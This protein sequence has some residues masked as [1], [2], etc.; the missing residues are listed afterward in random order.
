MES[1]AWIG[2]VQSVDTGN[3]SVRVDKEEL[4]NSV[5]INQIV[6]I[7]STKTGEKIVGLISKIMRKA[8]SEKID[9]SSEP[10]LIVEN[11]MRVNLVGTLIEKSGIYENI[12]KRTLN[13]VPSIDAD[14]FLLQGEE[15]S[16]FMSII[17]SGSKNPLKIG[18][19]TISDESDAN[20]D[21]NKFFQRHAVIVGG[22]GSGKSWTV[23]NI[24]EKAA[25]L[26]SINSLVFDLH[27]EYKPLEDLPN[28]TL[29]KIAGPS[30]N[31]NE[32]N[33][34]FLP[35]WLLSYDEIESML[36][37]RSDSNA[38]NQ[39]RT[40]FDLIVEN[41]KETLEADDKQNVLDNFTVESPIPYDIESVLTGLEHK[42]REMVPGKRDEKQGPLHG[43]LTRFIQRLKSKKSDKRLN[44]IFNSGDSLQ[45]YDWLVSLVNSLLD[46]GNGKG[47]KIIDFSEVPSDI[48]P[49]ITGLIGRLIFSIQQWMDDE[50]RHPVALFCD[51]AHLYI[52]ANIKG[53][54]EEKGLASFERIAKEGRKYGLSLVVISQ[55]PS[56]VNK[57]ILSQCGNFIA[58]RLTN[59]DDQNVIKRLF[60]DNLG[61]FSEMLPIL[62]VGEGLIVGDA[63]L[64]PSRIRIDE[65][66]IR[67]NSATVDFWDEWGK[68]KKDKGIEQ[69]VEALRRQQK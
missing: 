45:E 17:S 40:L 28:T 36:L 66:S 15:L 26:Q 10:D 22:T 37:D 20:L 56:D 57:T 50:L 46:F 64:L 11:L 4:L 25:N 38:P 47:V 49:L 23:A 18:K 44:F 43:K 27:G 16:S 2:K 62:D 1:D 33:I 60:P 8:I 58:M 14:C 61:D 6:Q 7:R 12:F 42:D 35:Y 19:Y 34:V 29:L 5:Q 3:I 9:E 51:E 41:K 32:E 55:R 13:T 30:D 63:A 31:P 67:P 48:L 21:G 52:P 24:L 68:E 65:P 59:P 53:G 39:S 69:A 54:M